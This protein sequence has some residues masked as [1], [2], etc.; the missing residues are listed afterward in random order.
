MINRRQFTLGATAG[1]VALSVPGLNAVA[2]GTATQ[3]VM[4]ADGTLFEWE[5]PLSYSDEYA[6]ADVVIG[7]GAHVSIRDRLPTGT[8]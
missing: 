5:L 8:F 4:G 6:S 2:A 3:S 1:A 7:N